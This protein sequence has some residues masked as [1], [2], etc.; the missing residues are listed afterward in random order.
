MTTW[1]LRAMD[2][3]NWTQNAIHISHHIFVILCINSPLF[4]YDWTPNGR[5][6]WS[7]KCSIRFKSGDWLDRLIILTF[8][9]RRNVL[10]NSVGRSRSLSRRNDHRGIFSFV[11]GNMRDSRI[12]QYSNPS[13]VSFICIS[14]SLREKR[15][16]AITLLP[17]NFTVRFRYL[18]LKLIACSCMN[19]YLFVV[20]L[21][22]N[23][24]SEK[25]EKIQ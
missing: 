16:H 25:I 8:C 2:S 13:I 15:S 17:S 20:F 18:T 11:N 14:V 7:H 4:V 22:P 1:H 5:L 9:S 6:T 10:I 23:N 19:C 24:A 12:L 3:T 21:I